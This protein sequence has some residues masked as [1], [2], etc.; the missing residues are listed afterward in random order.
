M[1]EVSFNLPLERIE[2]FLKKGLNT[3]FS[4]QLGKAVT[5]IVLLRIT[6]KGKWNHE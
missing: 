3:V 5:L 6:R 2:L 4:K 1:R